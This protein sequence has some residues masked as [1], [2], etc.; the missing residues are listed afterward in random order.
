MFYT[1]LPAGNYRLEYN[2]KLAAIIAAIAGAAFVSIVA[3]GAVF[4]KSEI[5]SDNMSGSIGL[6]GHVTLVLSDE[7][8]NVKDYR[9]IDNLVVD[10]GFEEVAKLAF[11][12]GSSTKFD[13]IAVGSGSTAP[14][15]GDTALETQLDSRKQDT[16]PSYDSGTKKITIDVTFAAGE[17][18]GTIRESGV[19]N[20][21]SGGQMFSRQT[22]A[23]INKGASDSLTITWEI[24]LS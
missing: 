24:T 4:N 13:Y 3:S 11:A 8:G 5:H 21:S 15:A 1:L 6:K 19:F 16:T 9:E 20:A 17:S 23:E 10:T 22:F 12:T 14:T 7:F 2:L 18:T